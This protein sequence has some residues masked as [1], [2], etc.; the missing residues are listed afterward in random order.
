MAQTLLSVLV[1]AQE[2]RMNAISFRLPQM[3]WLALIIPLA[4]IFFIARERRRIRI[5]RRF[6]SERLRGVANPLRWLRPWLASLAL[7]GCVIA[8]AGPEAGFQTIPIEQRESNRVI[9]IDVSLSMAA[10]DVGTSRLDAAKAIAK[11][12]IDAQ[13]GR[14]GLVVFESAAEVVSPLTSD[15]D[16]VEAL[17][18]SIQA[19]EVSNP[20][21]DLS[22]ALM[23]ALRLAGDSAQRGDIVVISDGEDQSTRLD[24]TIA[25]LAQ[26]GVPV[27]TILIGTAAGST[28]PRPEGG[29]DLV[30]DNGQVVTTYARPET[31]QKIAAA[32]GGKFYAN[33]FGEH[34]LDSLAASGGTLKQRNVR[35]PIERYQWPLAFACVAMFLGSLANRGAE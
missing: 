35:I 3:L 24:D 21:S 22:V 20:G 17:L 33:P 32:T 10:Q 25:K 7:L 11:R 16:A 12:I 6:V 26:R 15:G 4:L 19:G 13:Q 29:G 1:L 31:L 18:D 5:A 9:A 8:L 27:S 30:D 14:V 34:A 28:I 2:R 23:A